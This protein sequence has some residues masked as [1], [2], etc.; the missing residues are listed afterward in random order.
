MWYQY[1]SSVCTRGGFLTRPSLDKAEAKAQPYLIS[2]PPR[3]EDLAAHCPAGRKRAG[4]WLKASCANRVVR[5]RGRRKPHERNNVAGPE[6]NDRSLAGLSD[7]TFLRKATLRRRCTTLPRSGK[8]QSSARGRVAATGVS[9]QYDRPWEVAVVTAGCSN[10]GSS[11]N[12]RRD[13]VPW[14]T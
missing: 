14:G 5:T 6:R 11:R 8:P 9:G 2:R 3:G 12:A 10:G 1:R 4:K 13:A 7:D